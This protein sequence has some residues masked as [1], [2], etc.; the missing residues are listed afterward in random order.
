[1]RQRSVG[2]KNGVKVA[3]LGLKFVDLNQD[4]MW[5]LGVHFSYNNDLIKER[6]YQEVLN[7]MENVLAILQEKSHISWKD[8]HLQVSCILAN[9]FY[10][11][12]VKCPKFD[13]NRI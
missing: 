5:I 10:F 11:I 9:R 4:S 12:Y 7:K 8:L 1:M 13:H 6:N 3:L 2:V